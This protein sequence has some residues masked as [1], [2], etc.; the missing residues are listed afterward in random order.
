VGIREQT[1]HVG[2]GRTLLIEEG[3]DPTGQPVLVHAGTPSSRH[4]YRPHLRDAEERGIRLISYDRPGYGGSTA[5]PG[6]AIADCAADVL[7]IIDALSIERIAVWGISG[8]GPHALACAALLPDRVVAA[9]CLASPAPFDA[10]GL[11]W[12][13]GQAQDNVEDDKLVLSNPTAAR[14]KRVQDREALLATTSAW[15]ME[16]YPTLFSA[17][18]AAALTRELAEFYAARTKDGLAPGIDGWWDDDQAILTPWGF[19]LQ[20]IRIPIMLW[21]GRQDRFVPFRHGQWLAAHIP[22]VH[23][24]LTDDDGHLTLVQHRVPTVHAWLLK[25]F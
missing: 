8:G 19:D 13:A 12:F 20:E 16:I 15:I 3:G 25:H 10:A 1:V 23:T 17:I 21:H 24:E 7:A 22:N 14:V 11:D 4:L 9:A 5:M 18:D 2:D 6:R